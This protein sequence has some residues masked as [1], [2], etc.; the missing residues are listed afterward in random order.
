MR[1]LLK[2]KTEG[3]VIYIDK[4][5]KDTMDLR[6]SMCGT[7]KNEMQ[8]TIEDGIYKCECGSHSFDEQRDTRANSNNGLVQVAR[9]PL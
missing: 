4:K 3:N 5:Q 1:N 6:C 9:E 8:L 7:V 2:T